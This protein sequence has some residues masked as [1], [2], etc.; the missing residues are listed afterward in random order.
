MFSSIFSLLMRDGFASLTMSLEIIFCLYLF[1]KRK[2]L[3]RRWRFTLTK[4][5]E[6]DLFSSLFSQYWRDLEQT[7]KTLFCSISSYLEN[8]LSVP[9]IKH[10]FR[11][12]AFDWAHGSHNGMRF[13][14]S[15]NRYLR[16]CYALGSV[17]DARDTVEENGKTRSCP[18]GFS[19]LMNAEDKK[20]QCC[21]E[22]A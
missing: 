11:Y 15:I 20:Q 14:S 2:Q 1:K 10:I 19:V 17:L 12:C 4:N 18:P 7:D 9:H 16:A 6:Q 13:H 5:E 21:E 22:K 3:K 8:V